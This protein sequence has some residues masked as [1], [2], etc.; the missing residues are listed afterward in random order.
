[1]TSISEQ[2]T[3]LSFIEALHP[4]G[5]DGKWIKK[6]GQLDSGWGQKRNHQ[7][8][9][10]VL[11]ASQ[12]FGGGMGQS[13]IERVRRAR[14]A[15]KS[16]EARARVLRARGLG[17]ES[18]RQQLAEDR[19]RA[20][21]KA[22]MRDRQI[23]DA[24]AQLE[25]AK[26][27]ALRLKQHDNRRAA[28]DTWTVDEQGQ[29]I[30]HAH[31][32]VQAPIPVGSP[33]WGTPASPASPGHWVFIRSGNREVTEPQV[34]DKAR[35]SLGAA[36]NQ[37]GTVISVAGGHAAIDSGDDGYRYLVDWR[38]GGRVVHK[39]PLSQVGPALPAF[40]SPPTPPS[41]PGVMVAPG[42]KQYLLPG[43][44]A[45]S[46]Y[47]HDSQP[48]QELRKITIADLASGTSEHPNQGIQGS[49]EI[50][51]LP[52]GTK[53][54]HKQ[55]IY[56]YEEMADADELAYYVSQ[57]VDAGAPPVARPSDAEYGELIE[58]YVEG[59]TAMRWEDQ[60]ND[61]Y[62]IETSE[63]G[64]RI[65]LLDHLIANPDRH[66][67]NWMVTPDDEPV[68]IDMSGA[69]Q[70]GDGTNSPFWDNQ[71]LDQE[72][73][74]Q[75]TEGL[76]ALEPE[77]ARLG[78]LDWYRDMLS[79]LNDISPGA[80]PGAGGQVWSNISGQVLE[81]GWRFNPA[82]KRDEHG[83]WT[84]GGKGYV[85]P[86]HKRLLVKPN[87]SPINYPH[88]EDHPFFKAHP[89]SPANILAAYK[90]STD[91]EK[92][93][94]M[95][96]YADAHN[97]AAKM[98]DGDARKG[99]IL[100]A[101]YS[102]QV[103][104]PV[105]MF[106]AARS[107]EENRA[108]GPGDGMISTAM[109]ANAQEALDGA[110][111]DEALQ[112]PKTRAF[113]HLIENG[114]DA[115]DDTKGQVAVD[116]HA[117]SVAMGVRLPDKTDVPIGKTRYH[118]Y[119]ADQYREAARQLT[120]AGTPIA[121]HQIQA[122]TWIHQLTANQA[123]TA[124][125]AA[126][127]ASEE[128]ARAKGRTTMLKNAWAKW[129]KYAAAEDLPL[130]PGT[131]SLASPSTGGAN[132]AQLAS[133]WDLMVADTLA[134][135]ELGA[136]H[137]WEHE[138]RDHHGRW[139]HDVDL[140]ISPEDYK[141]RWSDAE[142]VAEAWDE[143]TPMDRAQNPATWVAR[144]LASGIAEHKPLGDGLQGKT[145]ILTLNNGT[146]VVQKT[147]RDWQGHPAKDLADAE[148]LAASVA[149]A[150][151][152]TDAPA[153]HRSGDN[154]VTMA[155][156]EGVLA[157][158]Y[159]A[160]H[161]V[162]PKNPY[163]A[164][165]GL[166]SSQHGLRIGMLDYLIDNPDR[167]SHNYLMKDGIPVPIDNSSAYW[168][169]GF[170]P[171]R[172]N[173]EGKVGQVSPF[174]KA[175]F[176]NP[177]GIPAAEVSAMGDRLTA[178]KADFLGHGKP[179]WYQEMMIR[180]AN[181]LVMRDQAGLA[182]T[183]TGQ[184]DLAFNP[185]EP[186]DTRGRWTK[187]GGVGSAAETAEKNR[188]G[189]SVSVRTGEPPPGGYM[190]AQTDH[191]H[192]YP[193]EILDDHAK[194]T[195]AIDDMI[196]AE[197]SAFTGKQVYLG[198][199][200]HD[201]K[202]WLEPSDN[203]ASKAEAVAAGKARN[204]ISIFDLQTYEEIQTGGHG[205]GHITEHANP[206]DAGQG[207]RGLRGAARGRA[208]GGGIRAGHGDSIGD[209]VL[210]AWH[211]NPAEKRDKYGKWA[212]S[213]GNTGPISEERMYVRLQGEAAAARDS[214]RYT[215][216]DSLDLG[217]QAMRRGNADG[218]VLAAK[219]VEQAAD[220][221]DQDGMVPEAMKYRSYARQ[222]RSM[223]DTP[224]VGTSQAAVVDLLKKVCPKMSGIYG[225]GHEAWNGQVS[226]FP[227]QD[228]PGVIG[229]LTWQGRMN[230][231]E[232]AAR[233]IQ[234]AVEHPDNVVTDPASFEVLLHELTHGL[235]GGGEDERI[236]RREGLG[237]HLRPEIY[238]DHSAAYQDKT[239][240]QIEEGFTEL[241]GIHHAPEF[242]RAAGV[243]DRKA[244]VAAQ[245]MLNSQEY[246]LVKTDAVHAMNTAR[247]R[248]LEI[249]AK[250]AAWHLGDGI[251]EL[252][253]KGDV[254]AAD[255]AIAWLKRQS[256]GDPELARHADEAAIALDKL[257]KV[258]EKTHI[259]M[260]DMALRAQDPVRIENAD[261]W[262]HYGWQTRMA[263]DWVQQVAQDEGH[264]DLRMSTPGYERT[265]ELADEVNR[266]GPAG[267]VQ[268]MATQV[269]RAAL[270]GTPEAP[271]MDDQAALDKVL[272]ST[273]K[274]ITDAWAGE[275]AAM[276]AH[277]AAVRTAHTTAHTVRMAKM[278]GNAVEVGA[279]GIPIVWK[280]AG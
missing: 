247:S 83:R 192:V 239:V 41:P 54:V 154:Q 150:V 33:D 5:P 34:G 246:Q 244:R 217:A 112:A 228:N 72:E 88:P 68:P 59:T 218:F 87:K 94:G 37:V 235:I 52:D 238:A 144:D 62:D 104:W 203:F 27:D 170:Y 271:L 165:P 60:G 28:M 76:T 129:V 123:V 8:S 143:L 258:Q 102:S 40:Q 174:A 250:S 79:R 187:F 146:K 234:S 89:V 140:Y 270:K 100:L 159:L 78:H 57:V 132:L 195:R 15:Q 45:S 126:D 149:Y 196:M 158:R 74:D 221:A 98:A 35:M 222:L 24:A 139:T 56:G 161:G 85:V 273:R 14:V 117:L 95:R 103:T 191:T 210:L 156:S 219:F 166:F 115:P 77:F 50:I 118:E 38:N 184:L 160:D 11:P 180:W 82:E 177:R 216:A 73:Y 229:E 110:T 70:A 194:L 259:T 141:K 260:N 55:Y 265:R 153:V 207:A 138:M 280:K 106:N 182:N 86:E 214:A 226:V 173:A 249:G 213:A 279:E 44:K 253:L 152:D 264:A 232:G 65:G 208:A 245:D 16:E 220:L 71:E 162:D 204:Q 13:T 66:M 26:K 223:K 148:E 42:V 80:A 269:V 130:I 32:G 167:H 67:N 133:A 254:D 211:F 47:G 19:F 255:E 4:R 49:V 127:P 53:V 275:E 10:G 17:P 81:M 190:V 257:R 189:F 215:M 30:R 12:R 205:G 151:E 198:G 178:M 251:S 179:L 125:Q 242:F 51:T 109:Q 93:Q 277:R 31:P 135:I 39:I 224:Q 272:A 169:N 225:G 9:A 155:F 206:Q 3:E 172:K 90:A 243:S 96:W 237:I 36:G 1:V 168:V 99:A 6:W 268:V 241:G 163:E 131:T 23:A 236:K 108:L 69:F 119:V 248:L 124:V 200:V 201:G 75:L 97:L 261:A 105:N 25:K 274:A 137:V 46:E 121:P 227:E 120:A 22:A 176:A 122:V 7:E 43:F 18:I 128:N 2:I 193:E 183:V 263:Q 262:G 116:R 29:I 276:D 134:G 21:G 147:L 48:V 111:V 113:A 252:L 181:Y 145:E 267:K 20:A 61:E 202:L 278:Q 230:I 266:E 64:Q 92:A 256:A 199:W 231:E 107:A 212:R 171:G 188:E 63:Q 197:K 186:R 240:A 233:S 136:N 101:S 58:G 185:R 91:Q 175:L 164:M 114:G 84:R 142:N 157:E 209:Q